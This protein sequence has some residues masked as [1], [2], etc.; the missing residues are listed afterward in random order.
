MRALSPKDVPSSLGSGPSYGGPT[1]PRAA[2]PR[3]S[4][5]STTLCGLCVARTISRSIL[6][7]LAIERGKLGCGERSSATQRDVD[8][9]VT[10]R[11][12]TNCRSPAPSM[13]SARPTYAPVISAVRVPPS[14]CSA[15]QSI[16]TVFSPIA[17]V[18]TTARRLRPMRRLISCV[19]PPI[20]P[21]TDSRSLRV[22]VERGSIAYSAVTH[23]LPEPIIHRGTPF[24]NEAV[25]STFV[26]PN[27][28]SALPSA[29]ALHPRSIV[30]SRRAPGGRPAARRGETGAGGGREEW[31]GAESAVEELVMVFQSWRGR[32]AGFVQRAG[33][34]CVGMVQF[35]HTD[36]TLR[37]G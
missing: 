22:F 37:E 8:K 33:L 6:F 9:S 19:R 2:A 21:L 20:F 36:K 23:P 25:Q 32:W 10:D 1:N 5:N 3:I 14:A 4:W 26:R 17:F 29:C 11:C 16:C 27:E 31:A 34:P 28:M 18:S 15:S 13:A 12:P 30:T 7:A 35:R 24:V